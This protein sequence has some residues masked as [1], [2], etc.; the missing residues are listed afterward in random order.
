MRSL[1][2]APLIVLLL[3]GAGPCA[4]SQT[5]TTDVKEAARELLEPGFHFL[6]SMQGYEPNL[7]EHDA[8]LFSNWGDLVLVHKGTGK[9]T[10]VDLRKRLLHLAKKAGW[11]RVNKLSYVELIESPEHYGIAREQEDLELFKS[12]D[13]KSSAS[14]SCRIWIS[15][16]GNSILVAYRIDSH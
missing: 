2:V 8:D 14:D 6:L 13:R 15:D 9:V 3:F 10:R 7:I 4:G 16:D 1:L 12:V 11:T 5:E